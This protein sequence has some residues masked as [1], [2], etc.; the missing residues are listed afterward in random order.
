MKST[1]STTWQDE[2]GK[3]TNVVQQG[4][5]IDYPLMVFV[6]SKEMSTQN[7]VTLQETRK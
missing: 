6:L 2:N 4:P 5:F 1:S 3:R 7:P